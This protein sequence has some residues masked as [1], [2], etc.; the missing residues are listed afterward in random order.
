MR[1]EYNFTPAGI[2]NA[3][4]HGIQPHEVWELLESDLRVIIPVGA[5]SRLFL[6]ITD[7]GRSIAV[8]VQESDAEADTWQVVAARETSDAED[9]AVEGLRRRFR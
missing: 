3:R 4:Q 8:L 1:G 7:Q 2:L 9:A 5:A 6:G